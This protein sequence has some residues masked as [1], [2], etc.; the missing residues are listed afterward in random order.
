MLIRWLRPKSSHPSM[1]TVALSLRAPSHN[2][3]STALRRRTEASKSLPARA[4]KHAALMLS[5]L[6]KK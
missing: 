4:R 6:C 2:G 5:M 1:T 3:F